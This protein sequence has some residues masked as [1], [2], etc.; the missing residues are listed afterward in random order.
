MSDVLRHLRQQQISAGARPRL[1]HRYEP[2]L[3][4]TDATPP[5]SLGEGFT[6]LVHARTLGRSIG[7]PQ[8]HL[9][10]EGM[11]PTG[12]FKD[13]GMVLAVAKAM[14]DG[15]R[16]L[17]CASTGNTSASAAAYG[18]AA[19]L[20][21]IVVLPVGRIAA[22]KL[23]QAQAAGAQIVAVDGNFDAALR[24]VRE[25]VE[26][27]DPEHPVTLVNSVNP[28]RLL[29]QQTAAFEVCDDLGGAPDYL[30]IPVGNA[31][32]I[33][34]Y[35]AGFRAYHDAQLVETR[36]V[37][38]GFQ[39]EGAAP[40]VLGHPVENP[41]TVATAIRIGHPASGDKALAARDESGGR[42]D[43]VTD[44]EI[45]DAYRDL[46]RH[47]GIFC[48]P[49]SAASVAGVRKMAAEGSIDPG[50]TIVC[51]LT[52]H[53]LKDPDTAARNAVAPLAAPATVEGVRQVL[54]W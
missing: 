43:T 30:A 40:L 25:M 1:L 9:K 2:F 26:Q 52:G 35:W 21:V 23:L 22:G 32:N 51:V 16:A 53:G 41:E 36:P 29:G 4:L 18:A 3:P 45:L 39:A 47:E 48:E 8:L 44:E 37:M 10:I 27:S 34:A 12:S 15:A 20:E 6:P 38:L 5:L 14:E 19:G 13:R 46:A 31:G 28:Y 11:N 7:C 49:A 50:A 33:S 24:I 17:I 54:G 42:I